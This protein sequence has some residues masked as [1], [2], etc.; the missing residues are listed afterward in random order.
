[1]AK[2]NN[3]NILIC[4]VGGQGILLASEILS[5]VLMKVGYDVKK[6][7]IHGMAQRGGSVESHIRAGKKV[8]SPLIKKGEADFILSF[9][10]IEGL[11]YLEYLSPKGKLIRN[12]QKIIPLT[13]TIG[14]AEYPKN[15]E[16]IAKQNDIDTISINAAE[17]ARQLG[18]DKVVN[19]ILLG[20]LA[21]FLDIDKKI[22]DDILLNWMKA[23]KLSQKITKINSSA[24]EKGF[25]S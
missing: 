8:Y 7:E 13:V 24:F 6:S 9:E 25:N 15:P 18:S 3:I 22:W 21:K 10:S 19:I 23:K 16:K 12:T 20:V 1:M 14:N 17:I 5:E 4:G 11:R 2:K